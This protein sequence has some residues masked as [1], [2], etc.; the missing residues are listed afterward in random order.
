ME[1]GDGRSTHMNEFEKQQMY[2][3][4]LNN[5][6]N[7]LLKWTNVDADRMGKRAKKNQKWV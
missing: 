4:L 3:R 5:N 1:K 7:Q 6:P 2:Y